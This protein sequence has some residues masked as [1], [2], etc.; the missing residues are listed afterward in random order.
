VWILFYAVVGAWMWRISP[1][2]V[3]DAGDES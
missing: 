3:D 1:K 2:P